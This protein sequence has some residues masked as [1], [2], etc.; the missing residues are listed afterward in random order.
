ML[1]KCL[2]ITHVLWA[3]NDYLLAR[4]KHDTGKCPLCDSDEENPNHLKAHCSDAVVTEIRNQMAND[5][6]ADI[7]AA[8]GDK[9]PTEAW[10]EM[11]KLWTIETL[12]KAHPD[13]R[14]QTKRPTCLTCRKHPNCPH[15]GLNEKHLPARDNPPH[16][17]TPTTE[18]ERDE[19]EEAEPPTTEDEW[20]V[21]EESEPPTTEDEWEEDELP[22]LS[23]EVR[24]CLKD[25]KAPG[26]R[27]H[28]AGW[29]P[30]SF[31]N[32]LATCG[33]SKDEAYELALKIRNRIMTSF[34][35]MWRERNNTKHQPNLRKETDEQIRRVYDRKIQLGMN[36]GVHDS[37]E[38]LIKLPH[39]TKTEWLKHNT[40]N[41]E[42][43]LKKDREKKIAMEE[44]AAGQLRWNPE[45]DI[46][47][48]G[49]SRPPTKPKHK[50]SPKPKDIT[51]VDTMKW[52]PTAPTR[53]AGT[54][55]PTKKKIK[56]NSQRKGAP[57][58]GKSTRAH[59]TPWA[60]NPQPEAPQ[61]GA[62]TAAAAPPPSTSHI[63]LPLSTDLARSNN[64]S[65]HTDADR[66]GSPRPQAP[67][68]HPQSSSTMRSHSLP[69][70]TPLQADDPDIQHIDRFI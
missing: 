22:T 54:H 60:S 58:T 5:I 55:K 53:T 14:T 36:M 1:T 26:A 34:D 11:T 29:F 57:A 62:S 10:T 35:N 47:T 27:T 49:S 6:T 69:P 40:K 23:P 16:T 48:A 31:A 15:R 18:D 46:S 24:A 8:L 68:R 13:E 2:R 28:W 66:A 67:T 3:T 4:G 44:W 56:G 21:N 50:A 43:K 39:R 7:E 52:N 59:S 45:T 42:T 63:A 41:I 37:V 17:D 51:S 32:L 9:L 25:M 19:N 64:S 33:I 65:P 70:Q 61:G 38:S 30:T 12:K 20:D